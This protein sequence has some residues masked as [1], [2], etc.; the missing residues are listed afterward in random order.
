MTG[1]QDEVALIPGERLLWS[2]E[3]QRRPLFERGDLFAVPYALFACAF[4][5]LW[6]SMG[7][8][9]GA[10]GFVLIFGIPAAVY[11]LYL[12]FGRLI[13]RAIRLGSTRYTITDRRLVERSTRPSAKVRVAYL[14]DLAPPI[15]RAKDGETIGSVAF[16][17]FPGI[18]DTYRELQPSV[19]RRYRP[20]PFVLREIEQARYVSDLIARA[21]SSVNLP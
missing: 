15:V 13:V 5:V 20:K 11:D 6:V 14:R 17:Q 8:K 21:Q 4:L 2:G 1:V 16:G 3:P 9:F 10:A 7:V 12:L 18:A 19:R